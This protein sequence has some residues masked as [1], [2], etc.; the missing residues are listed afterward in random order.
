MS[1]LSDLQ[2]ELDEL[3]SQREIVANDIDVE[4]LKEQE[5]TSEIND[6][7]EQIENLEAEFELLQDEIQRL[8]ERCAEIEDVE[9]PDIDSKINELNNED[10]DEYFSLVSQLEDLDWSIENLREQI[11]GYEDD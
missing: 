5:T 2:S 11:E 10:S 7:E 6:C 9:I 1:D 8:D 3:L 4:L